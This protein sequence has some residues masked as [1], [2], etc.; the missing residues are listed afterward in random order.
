MK[1]QSNDGSDAS[2][3]PWRLTFESRRTASK[4]HESIV[5]DVS[6][7]IVEDLDDDYE[8]LKAKGFVFD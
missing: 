6:G 7:L 2:V 1:D 5:K 3:R 4:D 8:V